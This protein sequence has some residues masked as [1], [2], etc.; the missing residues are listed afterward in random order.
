M[1]SMTGFGRGEV[2]VGGAKYRVEVSSVNR[3]QLDVVVSLPRDMQAL[4]GRVRALVGEVVAR[5][6]V[7][8]VVRVRSESPTGVRLRIDEGLARAYAEGFGRLSEALG[9][10]MGWGAAELLRAPGVFEL[11]LAEL[12]V[13]DEW[14][15]IEL[16][17]VEALG[18]L[19]R[20]R[21]SEGERLLG[22]LEG[23]LGRL[24]EVLGR[25]GQLA[26]GVVER[27]RERL[28]E[29]LGE[30]GVGLDL[31]DERVTR[32][33]GFYAER[34]DVRE[35][36]VRGLS[37]AAELAAALGRPGP[38]GRELDFLCQE[39]GREF[40]TMGVKANDAALSRLVVDGRMLLEQIREQ[41]QNV[42]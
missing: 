40:N 39:L 2:E 1:T 26:P 8:V 33:L 13:E 41:V 25:V 7:Q 18:G 5:G 31:D 4:E 36:L 14:Q 12:E 35:E 27:Y 38:V 15:G 30:A 37:H 6:R 32:E 23:L 28:R 11:E 20:M 24:G 9:R 19:V 3:K 17:L 22:E 16:A 29:R 42:E 10:E 34:C 21:G